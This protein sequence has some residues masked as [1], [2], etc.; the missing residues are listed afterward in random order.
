MAPKAGRGKG[1]GGGGK[2]DKRKKEE[3]GISPRMLC[4]VEA[5]FVHC[6][7]ERTLQRCES[8]PSTK[9]AC[10]SSEH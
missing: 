10:S 3:K 4:R 5:A 8:L 6:I 2:G 7:R 9:L 1:R